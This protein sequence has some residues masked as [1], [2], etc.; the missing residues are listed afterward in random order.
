MSS[1]VT[2]KFVSRIDQSDYIKAISKLSYEIMHRKNEFLA[3][4]VKEDP[5]YKSRIPLK[6]FG[7]IL[8]KFRSR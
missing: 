8:N 1:Y 7:E 3:L 4:C 5:N 6:T 2:N